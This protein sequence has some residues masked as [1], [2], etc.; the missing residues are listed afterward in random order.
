MKYRIESKTIEPKFKWVKDSEGDYQLSFIDENKKWNYWGMICPHH[1]D[2]F[3]IVWD[4]RLSAHFPNTLK[5]AK[6]IAEE[7]CAGDILRNTT[8]INVV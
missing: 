4:G 8:P 3:E 1:K 2:H 5:E 7:M 6:R